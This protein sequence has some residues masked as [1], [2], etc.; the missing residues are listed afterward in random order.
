MSLMNRNEFLSKSCSLD[1]K[2]VQDASTIKS[3]SIAEYK[4][5]SNQEGLVH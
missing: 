3:L 1:S 5:R 4:V 2:T